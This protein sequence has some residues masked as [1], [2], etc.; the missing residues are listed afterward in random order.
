MCPP[1]ASP[2]RTAI[3]TTA[4]FSTGSV[5]GSPSTTGSVCSLGSAPNAADEPE[6][7]FDR[8]ASWTCTSRP[9]TASYFSSALIAATSWG[10]R[11]CQSV[12]AS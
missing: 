6:K 5:P 9:M 12:A 4:R 11:V 10:S 8:V 3:C 7:I 1:T 2:K